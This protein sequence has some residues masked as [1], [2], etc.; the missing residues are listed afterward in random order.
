MTLFEKLSIK[1]RLSLNVILSLV[2]VGIAVFSGWLATERA[3]EQ[4]QTLSH[5]QT[6]TTQKVADF[7]KKFI[8]TLQQSNTFILTNDTGE[9]ERFN[10]LIDQQIDSLQLLLSE[11]GA[12]LER[13]EAG[14]LI[15]SSVAQGERAALINT[16]VMIDS[17][18]RM[19]KNATNANVFMTNRINDLLEFGIKRSATGLRSAINELEALTED[20]PDMTEALNQ[21]KQRL[22]SS[23]L[24]VANMIALKDINLKTEFD[25]QGLG[26]SAMPLIT[27]IND[28]F[29]G[30][31][32]N[33]QLARNLERSYGDYFDSF[34]DIRDT[35]NTMTQNNTS[36]AALSERSNMTLLG[37]M[38]DLQNQTIESL[39]QLEKSSKQMANWLLVIGL[40]GLVI[41]LIANILISHS[42]VNPLKTM[43][44]QLV[45][46]ARSGEF[47]GWKAIQGKHELADMSRA[48]AELLHAISHALNEIDSVSQALAQ[49]DTQQRMSND[50]SGDLAHLSQAFNQ[51]LASVENTL[52]EIS[53]VSHALEQGDLTNQ[54][55]VE[56]HQGQFKNVLNAMSN[57]IAVQKTA[58][59]DVRRVTHAM[60]EG[61]FN[62]RVTIEM[63]G[64]LH[65]LKRYLNESLERLE[66]AINNK[67]ESLLAFSQG[68]FSYESTHQFE[69]KLQELNSHMSNMAQSISHML[70]DVKQATDH[71]VH[72]MKEISSG[73]QDLNQR[74]QKQAI[75]LQNTSA[76]MSVMM[77][78][79]RATLNESHQVSQTSDQVQQDS[80]SGLIIVEQMVNAMQGIQTASK[81]IAEITG[82]I[83]SIAF[84]TN[85]L[86]LNAAVEAA[87]AGEA[88]RGFA[89]VATEVRSL[90]QRSAK[91]AQQIRGVIEINLQSIDKGMALSQQT[92]AVF[93]QNTASIERVAKMIV[94]MNSALKQQSQGIHEVTDALNEIDQAT[95]QN[96]ALVEQIASTSSSIIEEVLGLEH[97]VSSFKL[98]DKKIL[99][100]A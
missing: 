31:F 1:T 33:Q 13:N 70:Q 96:A 40:V 67:A 9:G 24:T 39:L 46:V 54:V 26:F 15:L 45:Q 35:L 58:I 86:A 52:N 78:S 30:D 25:Q 38:T 14:H 81:E 59:N 74:V 60:R 57:A 2:F 68:D 17:D 71:A 48:Q 23:Q 4:A 91:A 47:K 20:K 36:L 88:G 73:N 85:L 90:A 53:I 29:Q 65:N 10:L 93:E 56:K 66:Q 42:I 7:H 94:K 98:R 84:Q 11:F 18:L 6:T 50:Y 82:L 55:K 63:P 95:Q 61:Q 8:T 21:L 3:A 19:L 34:G 97:K 51:S 44:Q 62:Q 5:Q 100:A 43:Q 22:A 32:F 89:V 12:D 75:A 79:I 87:R 92:K 27:Q 37:L 41:V 64:E 76:N 72:G 69:G 28:V 99:N 16:L 83:D 77:G 49:G 80:A